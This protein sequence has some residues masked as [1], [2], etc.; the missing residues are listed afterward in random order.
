MATYEDCKNWGYKSCHPIVRHLFEREDGY[1]RYY[2]TRDVEEALSTC[3][4]CPNYKPREAHKSKERLK[5]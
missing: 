1:T 2:T 5:I 3:Q 4:K